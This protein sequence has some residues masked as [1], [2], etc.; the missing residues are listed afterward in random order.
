MIHAILSSRPRR[1]R[2]CFPFHFKQQL[3]EVV[4][5]EPNLFIF[6][7]YSFYFVLLIDLGPVLDLFYDVFSS[8][9]II[10]ALLII[11]PVVNSFSSLFLASHHLL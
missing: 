6:T 3:R 10:I 8:S 7:I 9:S 5:L 11:M 4:I 1:I 2:C